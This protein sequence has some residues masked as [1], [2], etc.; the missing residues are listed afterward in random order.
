MRKNRE[1]YKK[2]KKKNYT[3]VL[4]CLT[5]LENTR[6]LEKWRN[7]FLFLKFLKKLIRIFANKWNLTNN[8]LYEE[9]H[10]TENNGM[11]RLPK[12]QDWGWYIKEPYSTILLTSQP[13]KADVCWFIKGKYLSTWWTTFEKAKPTSLDHFWKM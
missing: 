6:N 8:K 5:L 4:I 2:K 13:T 10:S 11:F 3:P 7:L 1:L 12:T 9:F